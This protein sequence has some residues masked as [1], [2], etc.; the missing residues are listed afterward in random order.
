MCS[1]VNV[2]DHMVSCGR[3]IIV[4][5]YCTMHVYNQCTV[6]K[7]VKPWLSGEPLPSEVIVAGPIAGVRLESTDAC[8][9]RGVWE[10]SSPC[11]QD[12]GRGHKMR[13]MSCSPTISMLISSL[14]GLVLVGAGRWC[15]CEGCGRGT[16]GHHLVPWLRLGHSINNMYSLQVVSK[17]VPHLIQKL[18]TSVVDVQEL[19]TKFT[20]SHWFLNTIIESDYSVCC[21]TQTVNLSAR[22]NGLYWP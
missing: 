2:L 11:A 16:Q 18:T 19:F 21:K 22:S 10:P 12:G 20:I 4:T 3:R 17:C 1:R 13:W 8:H 9:R 15:H 6:A 5:W 7:C 14:G